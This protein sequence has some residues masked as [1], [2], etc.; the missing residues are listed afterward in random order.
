MINRI[1][2]IPGKEVKTHCRVYISQ[3]HGVRNHFK[4]FKPDAFRVKFI[5][6]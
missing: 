4:N 3:S 2:H 6:F 1:S 5:L